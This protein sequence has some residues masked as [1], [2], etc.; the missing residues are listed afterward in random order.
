MKTWQSEDSMIYHWSHRNKKKQAEN[1]LDKYIQLVQYKEWGAYKNTVR[2]AEVEAVCKQLS[3]LTWKMNTEA[4]LNSKSDPTGSSSIITTEYIKWLEQLETARDKR[5]SLG[6]LSR[7]GFVN[8]WIFI[9]LL[10]LASAVSIAAVH[11]AK[12]KTA[13][14][15]LVIFCSAIATAYSMISLH[16]HPYKGPEALEP[17][18]PVFTNGH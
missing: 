18:L 17:L 13:I 15:A 11:R 4:K 5:L 2:L 3:D 16:M 9:Y 8:K 1:K 14:L 10:T 12:R 7:W 6:R